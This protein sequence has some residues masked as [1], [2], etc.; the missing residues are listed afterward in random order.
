M[1]YNYGKQIWDRFTNPNH[2]GELDE[3]SIDVGVGLVGSPAC[4]DVLQFFI[5]VQNSL[6]IN[7][8][9]KTFGCGSA[10]ASSDYLA[11]LVINKTLEQALKIRN[12]EIANKLQLPKI[13]THCSVLAETAIK[14]AIKD[15]LRKNNISMPL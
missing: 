7:A 2:V 13:K 15:Y 11:E 12:I 3:S 1:V 8:M 6:I 10:I 5:Q 14:R 9:F 4:G